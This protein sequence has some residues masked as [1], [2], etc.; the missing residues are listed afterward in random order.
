MVKRYNLPHLALH[1]L[2]WPAPY[3]VVVRPCHCAVADRDMLATYCSRCQWRGGAAQGSVGRAV[4]GDRHG[5]SHGSS[6]SSSST[7]YGIAIAPTTAASAVATSPVKCD[8][9]VCSNW[10]ISLIRRPRVVTL[11]LQK[12]WH[13]IRASHLDDAIRSRTDAYVAHTPATTLLRS[14]TPVIQHYKG[15]KR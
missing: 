4:A 5:P 1:Q 2:R 8:D 12:C 14:H 10:R 15:R 3:C 7:E 11:R 13:S 9:P 6:R